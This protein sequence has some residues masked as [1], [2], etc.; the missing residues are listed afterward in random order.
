MDSECGKEGG[1]WGAF[2]LM[3]ASV[4]RTERKRRGS[5][6]DVS[7]IWI[8]GKTTKDGMF[9]SRQ[10]VGS[11]CVCVGFRTCYQFQLFGQ[12]N[13]ISLSI[14]TGRWIIW[15]KVITWNEHVLA[16]NY[17]RT[18]SRYNPIPPIF[19]CSHRHFPLPLKLCENLY[20]R[21][22]RGLALAVCELSWFF[23]FVF[24]LCFKIKE[25]YINYYFPN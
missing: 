15:R 23:F 9:Q 21:K 17:I 16:I 6:Q 25:K 22:S 2:L 7:F 20:S 19:N 11:V 24:K 1:E 13:P 3:K 14:R 18:P 10:A 12:R 4:E 8:Y 5:G